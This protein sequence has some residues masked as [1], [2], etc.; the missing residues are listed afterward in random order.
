MGKTKIEWTHQVVDGREIPGYTFNP[1]IGCVH[2]GSPGCDNCYAKRQFQRKTTWADC[3]GPAKTARRRRTSERYWEKPLAW[4][5]QAAADGIARRVFCAS[6]ADVWERHPDVTEWRRDLWD[7]IEATP[8]LDWL[9]LT[10][11]SEDLCNMVPGSWLDSWPDNAWAGVTVENFANR[12]RI[13]H[14]MRCPAPVRFVSFEPLLGDV[15]L[16]EEMARMID[17]FIVGSE[18]GPDR[19]PASMSWVRQLKEYRRF[20]RP[21]FFV[22]QLEIDGRLS[23]DPEEWPADLRMRETPPPR[24]FGL[25]G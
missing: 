1:W 15:V 3:W 7:L 5:R 13:Y 21:Y 6:L 10:K 24:R 19:R 4:N 8:A 11:R 20:E 23:H 22:K 17:W 14:L 9:L 12:G 2:A 16:S 18:S 25:Y